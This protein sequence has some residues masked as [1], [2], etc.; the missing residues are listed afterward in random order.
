LKAISIKVKIFKEEQSSTLTSTPPSKDAS[1]WF[2]TAYTAGEG[3]EDEGSGFVP[4][5]R[6]LVALTAEANLLR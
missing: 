2:R 1:T 5:A 6:L 3:C 4:D